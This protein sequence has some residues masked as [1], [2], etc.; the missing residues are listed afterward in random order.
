MTTTK[1][2]TMN[3]HPY[4]P[5]PPC[6]APCCDGCTALYRQLV[7]LGRRTERL[8]DELVG[9]RAVALVAAGVLFS[10]VAWVVASW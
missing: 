8:E 4:R 7:A 3:A 9:Y 6:A 2:G 1:G 10:T 5:C